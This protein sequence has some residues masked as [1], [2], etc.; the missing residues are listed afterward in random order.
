MSNPETD[1]A[2]VAAFLAGEFDQALAVE[3]TLE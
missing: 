1:A 3:V 2:F